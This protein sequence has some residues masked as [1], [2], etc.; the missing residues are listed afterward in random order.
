VKITRRAD[1]LTAR[2]KTRRFMVHN[3]QKTGKISARARE[4]E[5]PSY[6]GFLLKL[7][8]QKGRYQG[9][10]VIPQDNS[11]P[12]WRT[13]INAHHLSSDEYVWVSLSYGVRTD[14]RLVERIKKA[15]EA[16]VNGKS[17]GS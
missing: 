13:H 8:L 12:Y 16:A 17:G 4:V 14:R 6:V 9:A 3:I 5:G 7:D 2:Y 1:G 10:A 11:R 15:V